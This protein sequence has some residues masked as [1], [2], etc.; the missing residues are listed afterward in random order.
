M[1]HTAATFEVIKN[2]GINS[3]QNN[4]GFGMPTLDINPDVGSVPPR[5]NS[6]ARFA[7]NASSPLNSNNSK[8]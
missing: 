5:T 4:G 7:A 2:I 1:Q 8:C 3:Q 6:S